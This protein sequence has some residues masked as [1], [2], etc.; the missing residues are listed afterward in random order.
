MMAIMG[1]CQYSS[2]FIPSAHSI[3]ACDS[4]LHTERMSDSRGLATADA[5][6]V[7]A[8]THHDSSPHQTQCAHMIVVEVQTCTRDGELSYRMLPVCA[9][10]VIVMKWQTCWLQAVAESH[11]LANLEPAS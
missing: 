3:S 9:K 5:R 11:V 2:L 7:F 10:G 4:H 8:S 6:P 1:H